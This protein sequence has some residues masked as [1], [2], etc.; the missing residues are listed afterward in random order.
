MHGEIDQAAQHCEDR[1]VEFLATLV[2]KIVDPN[3]I[4]SL[5]LTG[6]CV[7]LCVIYGIAMV[8]L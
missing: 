3:A 4:V 6:L 1:K 5:L 2:P 8:S 7:F